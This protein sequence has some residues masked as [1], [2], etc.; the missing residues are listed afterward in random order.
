MIALGFVYH[1]QRDIYLAQK[2]ANRP[3]MDSYWQIYYNCKSKKVSIDAHFCDSP[4]PYLLTKMENFYRTLKKVK[5]LLEEN[6][7]IYEEPKQEP[8]LDKVERR[9]LKNIIRPF[10][11]KCEY[12][13]K[14]QSCKEGWACIL[15]VLNDTY[16]EL[17]RFKVNTMY[18]NMELSKKYTLEELGI[19]YE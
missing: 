7:L 9:Y 17:P 19:T 8:I 18:K 6:G 16:F 11:D 1:V 4:N 2:L 5:E 15:I 14:F 12:V 13:E 3:Y 10:K